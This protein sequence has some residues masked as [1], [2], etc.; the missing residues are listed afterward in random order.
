MW[1]QKFLQSLYIFIVDMLNFVFFEIILFSHF[2]CSELVELERDVV[3]V[4][5]I[6]RILNGTLGRSFLVINLG[7][8]RGRR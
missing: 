7:S 1:R 6:F 8:G 4:N 3:H 2:T 5:T